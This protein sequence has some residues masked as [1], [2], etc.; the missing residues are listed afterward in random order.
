MTN[1]EL[2][3][4]GENR[5]ICQIAVVTHRDLEEVMREWIDKLQVGPFTVV[6]MSDRTTTDVVMDGEQISHPFC[7]HVAVAMYGN[8]Q[9]ELIDVYK[10]Q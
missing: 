1:T 3:R 2:A 10:R 5:R 4:R 9:I 6:E 7:Y 8:L